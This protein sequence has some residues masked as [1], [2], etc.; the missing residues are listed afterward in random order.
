MKNGE[1]HV[2]LGDCPFSLARAITPVS[3]IDVQAA[4]E[5]WS[6]LVDARETAR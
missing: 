6:A 1:V 4:D 2:S 5:R 3:T